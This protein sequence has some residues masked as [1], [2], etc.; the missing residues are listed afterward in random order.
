M[1][2]ISIKLESFNIMVPYVN[3]ALTVEYW[4][5][6]HKDPLIIIVTTTKAAGLSLPAATPLCSSPE[7]DTVEA[8][9]VLAV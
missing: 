9:I 7:V 5:C 4:L 6:N 3:Y 1:H 8:P 2:K